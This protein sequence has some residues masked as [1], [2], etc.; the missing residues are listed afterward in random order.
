[1]IPSNN[2]FRD[3]IQIKIKKLMNHIH[4]KNKKNNAKWEIL[5]FLSKTIQI[6]I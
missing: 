1:M 3:M 2:L 5:N 6:L 4:K